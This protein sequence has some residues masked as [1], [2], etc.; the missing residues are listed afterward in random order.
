MKE[1]LALTLLKDHQMEQVQDFP[2]GPMFLKKNVG[3]IANQMPCAFKLT[4]Q[5]ALKTTSQNVSLA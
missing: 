1:D 2:L 5:Q 3:H 4:T